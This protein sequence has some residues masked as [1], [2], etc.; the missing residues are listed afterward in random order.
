MEFTVVPTHGEGWEAS[1]L[2]DVRASEH[3]V[4]LRVRPHELAAKRVVATIATSLPDAS[5]IDV[6]FVFY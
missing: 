4:R 1:P 3:E 6:P 5:E 2:S